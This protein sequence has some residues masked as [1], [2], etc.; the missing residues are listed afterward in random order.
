LQKFDPLLLVGVVLEP[1]MV[2]LEE[3]DSRL[4]NRIRSDSSKYEAFDLGHDVEKAM[5]RANHDLTAKHDKRK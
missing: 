5:E 2:R 1:K 3:L 4:G